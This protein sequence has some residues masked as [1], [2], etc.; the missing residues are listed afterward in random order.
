MDKRKTL[1][2]VSARTPSKARPAIDLEPLIQLIADLESKKSLKERG[3]ILIVGESFEVADPLDILMESRMA[4]S[5]GRI[6]T[7]AK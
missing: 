2:T 1:A 6:R 7:D 4:S 5:R 3:G